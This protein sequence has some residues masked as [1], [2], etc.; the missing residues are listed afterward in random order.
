MDDAGAHLKKAEA[1]CRQEVKRWL[2]HL[3]EVRINLP[4][5]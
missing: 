5:T 3:K 2:F 4:L 1:L